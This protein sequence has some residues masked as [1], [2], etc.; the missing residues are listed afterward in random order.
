MFVFLLVPNYY[1]PTG[2]KMLLIFATVYFRLDV[3]S[4]FV[5]TLRS[6][7][8]IISRTVNFRLT[9]VGRFSYSL[10]SF[11]RSRPPTMDVPFVY[12]DFDCHAQINTAG[13]D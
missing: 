7:F 9:W 4:F 1:H 13:C 10:F 8:E 5:S 2:S 11:Y 12:T 3:F 6:L